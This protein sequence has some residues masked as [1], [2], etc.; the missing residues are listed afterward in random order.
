MNGT[1][2]IDV[3]VEDRTV[4]VW[5]GNGL[6]GIL[7]SRCPDSIQTHCRT[8]AQR[9]PIGHRPLALDNADIMV[10]YS[11]QLLFFVLSFTA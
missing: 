5:A 2:A 7:Q 9:E 10:L 3:N 1:F 11:P 4:S 8:V 6:R